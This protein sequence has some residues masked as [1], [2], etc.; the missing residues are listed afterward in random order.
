MCVF[1]S[2]PPDGTGED[3]ATL[4]AVLHDPTRRQILHVLFESAD[5]LPFTRLL[6]HAMQDRAKSKS[7]QF[8]YHLNKLHEAG[9]LAQGDDKR[10]RLTPLGVQVTEK[11]RE[12]ERVL[13]ARGRPI[14]VRTSRYQFEPFSPAKIQAHL[15]REAG[16]DAH[17]A[18]LVATEVRD[19]LERA[20]VQYLTA[21]LIREVV[22]AVL[23]ERGLE[24]YRH[25]LT[26]LGLPGHDVTEL[27]ARHP[28]FQAHVARARAGTAVLEQHCLL[29]VFP[30][31]LADAYLAGRVLVPALDRWL[32]AP[33]HARLRYPA[34]PAEVDV[35]LRR[36]QQLV[37]AG[38]RVI[39][40]AILPGAGA[41]PPV[42]SATELARALGPTLTP[43]P[44]S[45][46]PSTQGTAL[47]LATRLTSLEVLVPLARSF[48]NGPVSGH[49]D[50]SVPEPEHSTDLKP[51]LEN[52]WE[53]VGPAGLGRVTLL[54]TKFDLDDLHRVPGD[55]PEGG[56]E[57]A[58]EHGTGDVPKGQLGNLAFSW[59][60]IARDWYLVNVANL[61]LAAEQDV[62]ET[63]A[64]FP[65][66]AE[67]LQAF[68]ETKEAYLGWLQDHAASD[69]LGSP[70]APD[71]PSARAPS[72]G[73]ETLDVQVLARVAA[74][75]SWVGVVGLPEVVRAEV[76]FHLE[77]TRQGVA[78]AT[79]LL[80]ALRSALEERGSLGT[81]LEFR[82]GSGLFSPGLYQAAVDRDAA[83]F[84]PAPRDGTSGSS[85][86]E[87]PPVLGTRGY[88]PFLFR[89]LDLA[90]LGA[91][92]DPT[93]ACH[94]AEA[95]ASV[96]KELAPAFTGP[97]IVPVKV[98]PVPVV[99]RGLVPVVSTL[100]A[101]GI[102][103]TFHES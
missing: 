69:A 80:E 82:A 81:A 88:T 20:G 59:D 16:M 87:L 32:T 92:E 36:V 34:T 47:R 95:V 54:P 102:A 91:L 96:A 49:V 99:P 74:A 3:V 98:T 68:H 35:T 103:V 90:E 14:Q 85:S 76:G 41:A 70:E 28:G 89:P 2:S 75:P 18:H 48:L 79:R 101:R 33:Y 19:R 9:F 83:Q 57:D 77:R 17:L 60:V 23:V 62:E 86:P 93:A 71:A 13:R 53:T 67:Q 63:V 11:H 52:L 38:T 50:L 27:L 6:K 51:V 26:R 66:V 65:E 25:R 12:L 10:Y 5:P 8:A 73:L 30:N 45:G 84:A 58:L 1:V 72:D 40:L 4:L 43:A 22:N 29:S 24:A 46:P 56:F 39:T 15:A 64:E 100:L 94:R 7:S 55:A 97:L 21:P 31:D 42:L 61:Y 78:L 37:A 44:T